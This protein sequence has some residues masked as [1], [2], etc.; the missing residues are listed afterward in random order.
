VC[1]IG[2]TIR[3]PERVD[4]LLISRSYTSPPESVRLAELRRELGLSQENLAGRMEIQQ[5]AISKL[6]RRSDLHLIA[7]FPDGMERTLRFDDA[8]RV[9]ED[10]P[11]YEG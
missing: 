3:V 7:K 8:N 4:A 10:K 11:G 1:D 5:A 6:E 9:A 2:R